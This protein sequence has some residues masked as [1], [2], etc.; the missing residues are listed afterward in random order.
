ML[1][2]NTF[3]ANASQPPISRAARLEL[4]KG[5]AEF[6]AELLGATV[7]FFQNH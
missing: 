2:H 1:K 5:H 6:V 7:R 4:I 3:L